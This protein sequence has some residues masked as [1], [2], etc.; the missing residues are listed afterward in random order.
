MPYQ[1]FTWVRVA[2]LMQTHAHA[3]DAALGGLQHFE[4]QAIVLEHFAR[5]GNVAGEFADQAGDGG[6]FFFVGTGTPRSF[7]S[8]SISVLPLKM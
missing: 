1:A 6:G 7:S 2:D 4:A 3:F 8:R 5:L